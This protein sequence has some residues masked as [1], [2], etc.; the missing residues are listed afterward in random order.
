[1]KRAILISFI[2][3]AFGFQAFAGA[4]WY[5]KVGA[6]G[7]GSSWTDATSLQIAL[8]QASNGD[9]IWVAQGVYTPTATTDR[10]VAFSIPNGVRLIGGFHGSESS[11]HQ[12]NPHQFTSVLSGNIGDPN[13]FEDNS[14]TVVYTRKADPSTL[15][16]GFV[17]AD[18]NA[19]QHG[20]AALNDN[21]INPSMAGGAWFN[22]ANGSTSTPSIINC[23]FINNRAF[24]G[25]AIYNDARN[26]NCNGMRIENCRFDNNQALVDGGALYNN[27]SNRGDCKVQLVACTFQSNLGNYGGAILNKVD[28]GEADIII[29]DCLFDSNTARGRG[30]AV[31]SLDRKGICNVTINDTIIKNGY[32]SVGEA[33]ENAKYALATNKNVKNPS[34]TGSNLALS[35]S[36]VNR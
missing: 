28:Y 14:H 20:S 11:I 32:Q 35:T 21:E 34:T 7:N 5:V 29:Y 8:S 9:Q 2:L 27:S 10:T 30:S 3:A 6:N 1:M 16:D 33:V 13:S 19:C 4:T 17:I 22:E 26:G 18:G 12:R 15:V 23:T 31:Y 25:A 24:Y 36:T